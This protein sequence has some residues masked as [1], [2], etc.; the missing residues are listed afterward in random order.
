MLE[1]IRWACDANRNRPIFRGQADSA[2]PLIPKIDRIENRDNEIKG[3]KHFCE[4]LKSIY[5]GAECPL[6]DDACTAAA[7]HYGIA[8][9]L[10]D[11]TPD[12]AV[13][14]FFACQ[15]SMAPSAAVFQLPLLPAMDECRAKVLLPPPFTKRIYIQKGIFLEFPV[16]RAE[17]L[18]NLCTRIEFPPSSEFRVIRQGVEVDLCGDDAFWDSLITKARA[19]LEVEAIRQPVNGPPL[20]PIEWIDEMADMLY[21]LAVDANARGQQCHTDVLSHIKQHNISLSAYFVRVCRTVAHQL[22]I[23]GLEEMARDHMKLAE[24]MESA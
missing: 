17:L 6:S 19:P 9:S 13:A 8:T 4:L 11:F 15:N 16:P 21:W 12:P 10:L 5:E 22:S 1:N 18:G 23:D 14:L 20:D 24:Y 2:W 3:L 7:Q